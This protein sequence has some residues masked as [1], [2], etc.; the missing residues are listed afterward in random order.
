MR[1]KGRL[2]VE[3]ALLTP[4]ICLLLIY[5]VFLTL[6]AHDCAVC[7]HTALEAGIRGI[8]RDGA[9]DGQREELI[10]GDLE[11]KLSRQLLWVRETE[12]QV[13]VNPVRA[14]VRISGY[15]YFFPKEKLEVERT[16]YRTAPGETVRRSRWL[17]E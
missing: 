3:A 17:R 13:E 7:A 2:V 5:A 1:K 16:I 11:Q 8:Y 15:G 6:Y 9:G 10:R 12:I 14:V 4:G